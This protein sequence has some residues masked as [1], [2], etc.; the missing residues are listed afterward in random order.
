M[1]GRL[2]A[3]GTDLDA[4]F[5]GEG[6]APDPL[7]EAERR[8]G[9][10]P[11][12]GAEACDVPDWL[13]AHMEADGALD[14]E[15]TA[16]QWQVRAPVTIRVNAAVSDPP[17]VQA[18]L[19]QDK[20]V[21]EPNPLAP[22][23]LTVTEGARRLR[24]SQAFLTGAFELQDASSQAVVEHLPPAQDVLDYCAGGGGKALAM[25]ARS[26]R[27]TAH[28]I[29]PGRMRDLPDRAMRAGARLDYATTA[30]LETR[31]FDLVLCDAPCS[32]SGS[33]RR[34][35][36]A[37]WALTEGRLR[38]YPKLQ[39]EILDL[40]TRHVRPGG[41]LAYATCS[42]FSCENEAVADAFLSRNR[43][44]RPLSHKRWPLSPLGDGFFS[45]QFMRE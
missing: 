22:M 33:W 25:A 29:D 2:R 12:P 39:G 23:A 10:V 20:I 1:L 17:S 41:V 4:I 27:V 43:G 35:P 15:D 38:G 37:K 45:I 6:H 32:G 18:E 3:T 5:T 36:D 40:A 42:V 8:A 16:A 11:A 9:R 24:Q 26:M 30:E 31:T 7:T 21:A 13:W 34:S 44:W 28:D 14:A 19:A